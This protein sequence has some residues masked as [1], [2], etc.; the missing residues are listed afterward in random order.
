MPLALGQPIPALSLL[1]L[2]GGR[3]D[4]EQVRGGR[5][6]VL[7]FMRAHN[8]LVCL[9]H[10]RALAELSGMLGDRGV[11][12]VIV[13]PGTTADATR[14]HRRAGG[15]RV[16]SSG[17]DAAHR[18]VDLEKHLLMQHSGTFLID[19]EGILRYAR[20]GA[21]PTASFHRGELVAAVS[22]LPQNLGALG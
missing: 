6:A 14:V 4:L 15:L 5:S 9:H 17:G 10:V 1:E 8:C 21:L 13:V 20:S 18:A 7:F 19:S 2:D 12:P 3:T 16:V 22:Q 11:V